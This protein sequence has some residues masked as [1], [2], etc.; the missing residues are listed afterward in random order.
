M[1]L[2]TLDLAFYQNYWWCIVSLLGALL[3]FMLFVQGGQSLLYS[4]GKTDA[5]LA[6]LLRSLGKKWELTF[7]TL[8][9]F[10]G[11]FFASFPLFYSTS[12]GG[13]YWVWMLILLSFV[14]QAVSYE[15]ISR[16]HNLLGRSAY[17][18]FLF[19][20]GLLAPVLLGAAVSTLFHGAEFTVGRGNLAGL[21]PVVSVWQNSWH[22]LEAVANLWNVAL[23]LAVF[24]L[25]RCLACLHF[26]NNI[27]DTEIRRKSRNH[28]LYNTVGFLLC[29]LP[30]L[31]CLLLKTGLTA[32]ADGVLAE[33]SFKYFHNFLAAPA[34]AAFL[35]LG[36]VLVLAGILTTLFRPAFRRGIWPAGVG[37]VLVVLALLLVAG[38][39]E[40][41][42]Y[43]SLSDAQSSLTIRNS[44]SSE[45]TLKAMSVVSLFIPFVLAYI[46]WAWRALGKEDAA[47]EKSK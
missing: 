14:V 41:A 16:K 47:P 7:T 26:I 6:A 15:Y 36:V 40:T 37:T 46:C 29:F 2:G 38:L 19:A 28:L 32:D 27:G 42:F 24:F 23:G 4:L 21:M 34:A 43:P 3:V 35:L 44:S 1:P 45:V 10:G 8:V 5:Q 30:W 20:N 33:E 31:V 39:N 12:F 9:T 17:R 22:G 11:A 13:A 25:S 18:G